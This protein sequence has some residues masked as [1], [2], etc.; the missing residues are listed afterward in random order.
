ME[1]VEVASI[2]SADSSS[3]FSSLSPS[4]SGSTVPESRETS[5]SEFEAMTAEAHFTQRKTAE[6][7]LEQEKK[8]AEEEAAWK[9]RIK[10][11]SLRAV[12]EFKAQREAEEAAEQ[13]A[14]KAAEERAAWER[15]L[16]EEKK[17]ALAKGIE[18][19]KRELEAERK[20]EEER[21]A[22][23]K[24]AEAD[25]RSKHIMIPWPS[26]IWKRS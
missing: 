7:A 3:S 26:M 4:D 11:E 17:A 19:A 21:I 12:L 9:K 20:K 5:A 2:L 8:A 16:E 6:A 24:Q 22:M 23:E 1:P 18:V 10:D 25:L 15:R 14:K 13:Q